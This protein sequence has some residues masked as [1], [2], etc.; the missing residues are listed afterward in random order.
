MSGVML[1][2][3]VSLTPAHRAKLKFP[4]WGEQ[5]HDEIRCRVLYMP[6][7]DIGL[8][9]PWVKYESYAGGTLYNM[10]EFTPKF[11]AYFNDPRTVYRELDI[12]IEV[13]GNFNDSY[14]WVRSSRG[15]PTEK[16]DK[17]TGKVAPALYSH[18]VQ[19]ILFDLPESKAAF[20]NRLVARIGERHRLC[21]HGIKASIPIGQELLRDEDIDRWFLA[22]RN[23]GLEG[24][25]YKEY[26][27]KYRRG[28]AVGGWFKMKPSDTIDGVVTGVNQA[29]SDSGVPL[30]RAGS[31]NVRMADGSTASPA[32]FQHKLAYLIWQNPGLYIGQ[33][34]EFDYMER[35]RAGGYRH[36]TF[37]RFREA[38]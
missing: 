24:A 15:K 23:N 25:M 26:D 27:H 29:V 32:G 4:L 20:S 30:D 33:W 36:P 7:S 14:R 9:E 12:G 35:D 8:F 6:G 34:L 31:V 18:M 2:K 38:K 16:L 37:K 28:K 10:E 17:K 21:V 13:N 3:G 19:I 5:K 11:M 22:C 1:M